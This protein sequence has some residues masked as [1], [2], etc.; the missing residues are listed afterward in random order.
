MSQTKAQLI[1][2][3]QSLGIGTANPSTELD[4][5][6]TIRVNGIYMNSNEI[7]SNVEVPQ[8][9]NAFVVGPIGITP[10]CEV[11]I[12]TNSTFQVQ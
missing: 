4:V 5:F 6:G 12:G 2:N 8:N 9:N 1:G 3:I 10:G 11:G 7:S